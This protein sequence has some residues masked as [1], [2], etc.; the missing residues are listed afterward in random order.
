MIFMWNVK[1]NVKNVDVNINMYVWV[2]IWHLIPLDGNWQFLTKKKAQ[3]RKQ[4][5]YR[6]KNENVFIG[7]KQNVLF[8]MSI[9]YYSWN[10][11]G[12]NV[13]RRTVCLK[14]DG[15]KKVVRVTWASNEKVT[16][17]G[18]TRFILKW[19]NWIGTTWK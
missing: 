9:H 3:K 5:K 10:K 8:Y 1:I 14:N 11:C 17:I 19:Y 2:T 12:K 13:W 15:A 6:H 4:Q 18:P 7:S 16:L